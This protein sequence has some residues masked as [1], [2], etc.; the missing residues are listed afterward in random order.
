MHSS[1]PV[2][3]GESTGPG[4]DKM[5]ILIQ[6]ERKYLSR[7][8]RQPTPLFIHEEYGEDIPLTLRVTR[9][10]YNINTKSQLKVTRTEEMITN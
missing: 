2:Q 10:S 3:F 4:S 6:T 9:I 5:M 1:I 8:M 7:Y